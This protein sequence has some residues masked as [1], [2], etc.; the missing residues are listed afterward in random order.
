MPAV[1]RAGLQQVSVH[2]ANAQGAGSHSE[3]RTV[4][5]PLAAALA[6]APGP[7]GVSD[8][9][10]VFLLVV[11]LCCGGVICAGGAA[12]GGGAELWLATS[13]AFLLAIL[14][15]VWG[16]RR[17]HQSM[18]EYRQ[19]YA[20]SEQ[21]WRQGWY[22]SRCGTVHLVAN[23]YAGP[24]PAMGLDEFR[25]RVWGAG[26]FALPGVFHPTGG[27]PVQTKGR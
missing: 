7:T 26:G 9:M 27:P 22:C 4:A 20:R 18:E 3:L 11:L 14:A 2:V 16:G 12:F 8:A 15:G 19:R 23:P 5:T 24:S 21:I 25:R 13:V 10:G 6:P 17:Y 1:H